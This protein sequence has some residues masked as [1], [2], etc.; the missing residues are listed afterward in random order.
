MLGNPVASWGE[1]FYQEKIVVYRWLGAR[2]RLRHGSRARPDDPAGR[3]R[4]AIPSSPSTTTCSAQ[5]IGG[6][7]LNAE[8][9]D[10]R[11]QR[12][13]HGAAVQSRGR[14]R[15]TCR[16]S[17]PRAGPMLERWARR[18]T[19]CAP[20]NRPRHD[21]GHLSGAPGYRARRKPRRRGPQ[22]HRAGRREIPAFN[23]IWKVALSSLRLPPCDPAS[24][25]AR[26]GPRRANDARRCRTRAGKARARAGLR[27]TTSC[28]SSSPHATRRRERPCPTG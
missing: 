14:A 15:L 23:S 18:G 26:D 4:A 12:R 20:R 25:R 28:N 16:P 21:A 13:H 5:A 24:G 11:W 10:W 2:D 1:D 27:A 19:G 9:E 6:G 3:R 22:L 17:P 7:L 8:G